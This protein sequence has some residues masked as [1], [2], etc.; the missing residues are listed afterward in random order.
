MPKDPKS[1]ELGTRHN[2]G[3]RECTGRRGFDGG[4]SFGEGKGDGGDFGGVLEFVVV[5]MEMEEEEDEGKGLE[6]L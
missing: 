3:R 4:G 2:Y 1:T 6:K 5:S